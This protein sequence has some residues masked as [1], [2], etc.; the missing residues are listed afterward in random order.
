MAQ[1]GSTQICTTRGRW[2]VFCYF[3]LQKIYFYFRF[4]FLFL[5]LGKE[6]KESSGMQRRQL[7]FRWGPGYSW[8]LWHW[9][10]YRCWYPSRVWSCVLNLITMNLA[11]REFMEL[12][13]V[14][15]RKSACH[16]WIILFIS[17]GNAESTRYNE[18]V[19]KNSLKFAILGQLSSPPEGFEEVTKAHF[20]LKRHSLIKVL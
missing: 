10:W 15:R 4:A 14:K 3:S 1:S 18:E 5:A 2:V 12:Q 11:L 17:S 6:P 13:R 8:Q 9:W 20:Y 7:S 16:D 19:F